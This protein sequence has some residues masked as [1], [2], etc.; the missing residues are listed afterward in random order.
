MNKKTRSICNNA[1]I[2]RFII[3]IYYKL[4]RSQNRKKKKSED[5][6]QLSLVKL[7]SDKFLTGR[8]LEEED[9]NGKSTMAARSFAIYTLTLLRMFIAFSISFFGNSNLILVKFYNHKSN[10]YCNRHK[11]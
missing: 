8:L 6:E 2:I 5:R 3:N 9:E 10:L 1:V 11:I 4:E 7:S